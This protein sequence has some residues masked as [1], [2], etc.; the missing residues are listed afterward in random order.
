MVTYAGGR[1]IRPEH[2][3]H[4]FRVLVRELDLP[5][6]RLHDLRYGAATLALASHTDLKIIQQML[7]HS[8]IAT[9]AGTFTSVLPETAHR[10]VQATA[11]MVIKAASAARPYCCW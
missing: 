6:I 5:P 9:T 8:S 7:G 10:A 4:R 11:A 2:L 1:P 3:S